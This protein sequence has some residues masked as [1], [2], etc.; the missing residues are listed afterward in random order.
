MTEEAEST[1][2]AI[3]SDKHFVCLSKE[4]PSGLQNDDG[5]SRK[6]P[7]VSTNSDK[8][9]NK[10]INGINTFLKSSW[11]TTEVMSAWHACNM[12]WNPQ[13]EEQQTPFPL[14]PLY[15]STGFQIKHILFLILPLKVFGLW[16]VC[17][18]C[19]SVQTQLVA[20]RSCLSS[21][22]AG[23]YRDGWQKYKKNTGCI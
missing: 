6:C 5:H 17:D 15:T 22:N 12:Q 1:E 8:T 21:A 2:N 16:Y 3:S 9:I 10:K 11:C 19:F 14:R 20:C 4:T 23:D 13:C 18:I 7:N